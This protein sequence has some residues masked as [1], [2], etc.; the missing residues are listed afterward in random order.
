MGILTDATIGGLICGVISY[1]AKSSKSNQ[2]YNTF[3]K[4]FAY[5]WAAPIFYVYVIFIL[6]KSG[7]DAS[8]DSFVVH[9]IIGAILSVLL[10]MATKLMIN[11]KTSRTFNMFFNLG[12]CI[13]CVLVYF[14]FRIYLF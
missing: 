10:L 6:L 4:I 14:L 1:F 8:V 11:L 5:L 2:A 7:S 13:V 3:L 9:A 12:F